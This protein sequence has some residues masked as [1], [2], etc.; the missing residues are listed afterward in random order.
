MC[1]KKHV[2]VCVCVLYVHVSHISLHY[3]VAT[4]GGLPGGCDTHS[5]ASSHM[6]AADPLSLPLRSQGAHQRRGEGR[7]RVR[8]RG[9][10]SG[11]RERQGQCCKNP[12]GTSW[13]FNFKTLHL[14]NLSQ[15]ERILAGSWEFGRQPMSSLRCR[16][17][18][19][20]KK[21]ECEHALSSATLHPSRVLYVWIDFRIMIIKNVT[22]PSNF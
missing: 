13:A 18:V 5:S 2:R 1:L 16:I 8:R 20:K 21:L 17:Q 22:L 6:K 7:E 15:G 10:E 14:H 11:E 9:M 19:G 12:T 3:F 4:L